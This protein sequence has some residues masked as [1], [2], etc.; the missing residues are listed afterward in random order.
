MSSLVRRIKV[1]NRKQT[2]CWKTLKTFAILVETLDENSFNELEDFGE[3]STIALPDDNFAI[4]ND[5]VE[6]DDAKKLSEAEL[7][8]EEELKEKID[9]D[10][11]KLE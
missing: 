4:G 2:V 7:S 1:W 3:I 10:E 8:C 5:E 11:I 6:G 9:D